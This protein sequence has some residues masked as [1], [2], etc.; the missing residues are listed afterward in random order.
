[1]EV[2]QLRGLYEK[3]GFV[4]DARDRDLVEFL[5]N[6]PP[7]PLFPE[8]DKQAMEA[9]LREF[10]ADHH[11]AVGIE[12]TINP[13]LC[14]GGTPIQE[15]V[16]TI[17]FLEVEASIGM[18][19]L[20]VSGFM[21]SHGPV[22]LLFDPAGG[23]Y[24]LDRTGPAPVTSV[25]MIASACAGTANLTFTGWPVGTGVR[26]LDRDEDA[27]L[28]GDE[29]GL[30]TDPAD[31][32]SDEDGLMDGDEAGFGTNPADPDTDGDHALDGREIFDGTDP[33]S[34][35]SSL[36][37]LS[38]TFVGPSETEL[39]WTTVFDRRYTIEGVD[40]DT[41]LTRNAVFTDLFT[42]PAKETESPEGTESFAGSN[43]PP[44]PGSARFYH[45]KALPAGS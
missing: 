32:D 45:V 38:V 14:P 31:P 42:T 6:S 7:F 27:V 36:R 29:A 17:S 10:A 26:S 24:Q 8:I 25:T 37:F 9:F 43:P 34:S 39:V 19:E 44:P 21:A 4:H 1:M 28:N 15:I 30:G 20:S 33:T 18:I 13:G 12:R 3:V 35:A 11:A 16:D 22:H 2:A 23:T 40:E 5:S 41:F